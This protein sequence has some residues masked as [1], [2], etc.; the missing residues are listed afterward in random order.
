MKSEEEEAP[1]MWGSVF[2]SSGFYF[3]AKAY[4]EVKV[5]P[6]DT[7]LWGSRQKAMMSMVVSLIR[8]R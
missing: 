5:V 3:P 6:V 7:I 8:V 4:A 1:R 2:L